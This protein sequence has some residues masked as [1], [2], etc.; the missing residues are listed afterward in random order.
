MKERKKVTYLFKGRLHNN[1]CTY[2]VLIPQGGIEMQYNLGEDK[3]VTRVD[4]AMEIFIQRE[5]PKIQKLVQ[6]HQSHEVLFVP[7]SYLYKE[8]TEK[9]NYFY[10]KVS[11]VISINFSILFFIFS[12]PLILAEL[13]YYELEFILIV[14]FFWLKVLQ[15]KWMYFLILPFWSKSCKS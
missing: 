2:C 5:F 9:V 1:E 13:E 12:L 3:V 4:E 11:E 15:D 8:W 14:T 6:D 7:D 10:W